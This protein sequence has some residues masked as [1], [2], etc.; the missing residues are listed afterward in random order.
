MKSKQKTLLVFIF[1]SFFA[2]STLFG[3]ETS[4]KED[5]IS[6][7]EDLFEGFVYYADQDRAALKSVKIRFPSTLESH[8]LGREIIKALLAGPSVPSL[9]PTWPKDAK[10]NSFF[11]ADDG[12]AYVDLT[13]EQGKIENM[14]TQSELLAIYSMVNSLTMNIP[15]IK[16]V[17]L[18]IDG[19]DAMT[20]AGHI[21][22]EYFYKTNMLIVK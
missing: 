1:L 21:D 16:R 3:A 2:V 18:L 10:L 20:L 7:Y 5:G 11:I 8:Q 6:A 17:K 4:I 13:I 15:K 14:D 22:L 12:T 19:M 9:E